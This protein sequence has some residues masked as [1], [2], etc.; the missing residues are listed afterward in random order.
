M[1]IYSI[2]CSSTEDEYASVIFFIGDVKKNNTE[3]DIGEIIAEN[4]ILTT[5]D[6][7][8]CDV[9]IGG[10][11]IRIKE[12]SSLSISSLVNKNKIENTIL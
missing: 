1:L 5:G 4:D 11:F 10:S 3:I 9:K 7:S 12:K 6:I 2:G 8:S